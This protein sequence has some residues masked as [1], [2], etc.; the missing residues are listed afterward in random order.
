MKKVLTI[1]GAM[2]DVFIQYQNT[3]MIQLYDAEKKRSFIAIQEG[4][5]IEIDRLEYYIG[6]GAVNSA[7]SF[8][9]LGFKIESFFKV[10]ADACGDFII[11]RLRSQG[12]SIDCIV[13]ATNEDTGTSFIIPCSSGNRS[14]LIYRGANLTLVQKEVPLSSIDACD[15]LYI[16]SL[17]KQA[18]KLLCGVVLHAK[19]QDKYV[20][21]NPGTSQL[22]ANVHTLEQALSGID[23]LIVNSF[24]AAL[25]MKSLVQ[26]TMEK[27]IERT[28]D[29]KLPE[30]LRGP[31]GLESI[32]FTLHQFFRELTMRGPRV[33][34][35]TNGSEGVYVTDGKQIYFH[36]SVSSKIVCTLGAGD[37]FG[38]A[39]VAYLVSGHSIESAIRAG[40]C[41]A[42]SVLEYLD[43]QTGLLAGDELARR[44]KALNQ[45]LLQVFSL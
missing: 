20:A 10:G 23:T 4:R 44:E 6:G 28:V 18:S 13:R 14:V 31:I 5:K 35:V 9:R 36:P 37:A 3:E 43:T 39:F 41:N 29:K 12:V 2:R 11:E 17:S 19:K 16:T 22:V 32:C 24:E 26:T 40:S 38:S 25:L 7:A 42:S 45:G 1:G 30:L 15:V 33:V 34:V 27:K 8:A 21:I